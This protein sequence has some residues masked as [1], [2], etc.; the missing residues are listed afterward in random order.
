MISPPCGLLASAASAAALALS[1][2]ACLVTSPPEYEPPPQ[3]APQLVA[4]AAFPSLWKLITIDE[5]TPFLTFGG[6]VISEDDGEDVQFVLYI[7]YG[8]SN[9]AMNPYKN[10]V[11]PLPSV[12]AGKIADG[13]RSFEVPWYLDSV[14]IQKGCHTITLVASHEFEQ[15]NVCPADSKDMSTIEW[16]LVNCDAGDQGCPTQCNE[17][18]C[19]GA[20]CARCP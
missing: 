5:R 1:L 13:Q 17:P 19:E 11:F 3:T 6:A 18:T 14:P 9:S 16:K 20:A 4:S 15:V 7:D 12:K 8:T 2:P 10:R